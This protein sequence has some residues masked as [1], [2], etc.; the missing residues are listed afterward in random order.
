MIGELTFAVLRNT[1]ESGFWVDKICDSRQGRH[2]DK[3]LTYV[4]ELINSP[5]D[6]IR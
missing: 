3:V 4:K 5:D 6:N 2:K 1:T